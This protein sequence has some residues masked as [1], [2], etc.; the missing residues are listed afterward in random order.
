MKPSQVINHLRRIASGIEKSRKPDKSLVARD[1]KRILH[2]LSCEHC[3]DY[4]AI[5]ET[6]ADFID[7]PKH[8]DDIRG[9]IGF[10]DDIFNKI[11]LFQRFIDDDRRHS[12]F[13]A[14]KD[15]IKVLDVKFTNDD[16]GVVSLSGAGQKF[17]VPFFWDENIMDDWMNDVL[18]HIPMSK[19]DME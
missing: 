5:G 7:D 16:G 9:N 6:F 19:E 8:L 17:Q 4:G 3:L 2:R 18:E 13:E 10:G 1:I 14:P 11:S 15:P 12:Y